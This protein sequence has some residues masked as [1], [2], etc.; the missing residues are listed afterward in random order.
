GKGICIECHSGPLLSDL[1]C[2]ATGVPQHGANVQASDNG[3]GDVTGPADNGKFLT[4]QLREIAGTGPYMHDGSLATLADVID[5]YRRGGGANPN[6]D[7]VLA[8]LGLSQEE[9]RD[10]VAFLEAL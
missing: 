3:C 5:F 7:P 4:G 8:P 1:R 2:H 6:L 9:V 10:L